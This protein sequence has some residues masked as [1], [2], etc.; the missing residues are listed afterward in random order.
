VVLA[1]EALKITFDVTVPPGSRVIV[2]GLNVTF[3][4]AGRTV[5]TVSD[6]TPA[7][8]FWLIKVKLS[9][10]LEPETKER[11]VVLTVRPK[12]ITATFMVTK[13][14]RVS[15]WPEASTVEYVPVTVATKFPAVVAVSVT[16]TEHE[17]PRVVQGLVA[18]IVTVRPGEAVSANVT[19]SVAVPGNPFKAVAVIMSVFDTPG[20]SG[21]KLV[22]LVDRTTFAML[23]DAEL[24]NVIPV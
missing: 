2:E 12:S 20:N 13:L 10:A 6:T 22:L 18:P 5:P 21:P 7:K 4:P 17:A 9:E 11:D 19:E 24:L 23:A 16:L 8:P 3:R 15:G 1:G 14:T